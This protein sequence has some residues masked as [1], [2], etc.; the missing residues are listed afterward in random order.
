MYAHLVDYE[1]YGCIDYRARR[2]A[3]HFDV[4]LL[5]WWRTEEPNEKVRLESR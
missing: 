5:N 1:Y 4:L 2:L 3:H